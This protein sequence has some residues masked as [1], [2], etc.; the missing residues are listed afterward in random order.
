MAER[1]AWMAKVTYTWL[2]RLR[3]CSITTILLASLTTGCAWGAENEYDLVI[4]SG[5]ILDGSGNPWFHGDVAIRGDRIVAIGRIPPRSGKREIHVP[6][7]FVA[8]GFIDIHSHSDLLLLEDGSAASKVRQGVTTEV[9][10]EGNS[11]APYP[12]EP[13]SSSKTGPRF[14]TLPDYFAALEANGTAVNVATYVGLDNIWNSAMSGSFSRPTVEQMNA[15]KRTLEQA[16]QDGAYGL[17]SMLAMPPGSLANTDDIVELCRV[18]AR[19]GGIYSTHNRHEGEGVLD[20]V[21]E[22]ITIG[23]K[24]GVPVDIIHLKIADQKLWGRMPEVIDLIENARKQGI[25]VQAHV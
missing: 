11:A 21:T 5:R 3:G 8:P 1:S 16:M 15:M 24:A 13:E 17:S 12:G 7:R 14:R 10:G 22:A 9:L 18:V 19:F 4:R 2:R 20:A 25:H 23:E 6:G